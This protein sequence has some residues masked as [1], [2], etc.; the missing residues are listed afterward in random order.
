MSEQRDC[1]AAHGNS[2]AISAASTSEYQRLTRRFD[3]LWEAAPSA[4]TQQEMQQLLALI[5]Q[6][7]AGSDTVQ[8]RASQRHSA[9]PAAKNFSPN[10]ST[11][12]PWLD[13]VSATQNHGQ[14]KHT[15]AQ[16]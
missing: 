11:A 8:V 2:S 13:D 9:S 4:Q 7:E 10:F 12:S 14:S 16:P 1:I 3:L 5:E 15:G 6:Y